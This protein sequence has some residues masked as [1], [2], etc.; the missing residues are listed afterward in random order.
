LKTEPLLGK[1]SALNP[2]FVI[3]HFLTNIPC[4][5]AYVSLACLCRIPELWL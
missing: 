5:F 2:L 3:F 1:V 4:S